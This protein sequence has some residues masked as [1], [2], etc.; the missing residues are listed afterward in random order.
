MFG[1]SFGLL[2]GD[3]RCLGA[4]CELMGTMRIGMEMLSFMF[5]IVQENVQ[6]VQVCS[7]LFKTCSFVNV[8]GPVKGF[9]YAG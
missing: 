5:L 2:S 3:C 6:T 9:M 8:G 4:L 1:L 7:V